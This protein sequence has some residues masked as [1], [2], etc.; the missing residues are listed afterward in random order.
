M[1][2]VFTSCAFKLVQ[3]HQAIKNERPEAFV[4]KLRA[5]NG[6]YNQGNYNLRDNLKIKQID[7]VCQS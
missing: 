2:T 7:G 4:L 3:L 6:N 5:M 1:R